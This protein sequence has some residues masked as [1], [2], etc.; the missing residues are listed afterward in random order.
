MKERRT[1][2]GIFWGHISLLY[3]QKEWMLL[4]GGEALIPY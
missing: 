4:K 1:G 3:L 2:I